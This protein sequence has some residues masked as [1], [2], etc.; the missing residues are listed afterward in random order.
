M[1]QKAP[2]LDAR[3]LTNVLALADTASVSEVAKALDLDVPVWEK[4]IDLDR[5]D[6]ESGCNCVAG[7]VFAR[8]QR[9][10]ISY[11][12]ASGYSRVNT[13]R[14]NLG[15]RWYL[16]AFGGSNRLRGPWKIA[17]RARLKRA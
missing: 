10:G 12:R 6:M 14:V 13:A 5:L 3:K 11:R 8:L 15:G 17:I 16:H 4:V 9:S 1:A 7:Q 2:T